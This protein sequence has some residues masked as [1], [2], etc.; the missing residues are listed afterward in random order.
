M[1]PLKQRSSSNT[2][3]MEIHVIIAFLALGP[4]LSKH[5]PM[6][7]WSLPGYRAEGSGNRLLGISHFSTSF[8]CFPTPSSAS[9]H[10][11]VLAH[12]NRNYFAPGRELQGYTITHVSSRR[13]QGSLLCNPSPG[14]NVLT[15]SEVSSLKVSPGDRINSQPVDLPLL[16]ETYISLFHHQ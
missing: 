3:A 13:S 2:G 5:H 1:A 12:L 16:S 9:I 6:S 7:W 14:N 8:L 11:Y 4:A 15:S 10:N